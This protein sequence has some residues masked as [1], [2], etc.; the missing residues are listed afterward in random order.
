[1]VKQGQ[2]MRTFKRSLDWSWL[3]CVPLATEDCPPDV[4]AWQDPGI[5]PVGFDVDEFKGFFFLFSSIYIK[6]FSSSLLYTRACLLLRRNIIVIVALKKRGILR[7]GWFLC[8]WWNNFGDQLQTHTRTFFPAPMQN[9]F[10][11]RAISKTT[12][13][14]WISIIP[15]PFKSSTAWIFSVH[16]IRDKELTRHL[17]SQAWMKLASVYKSKGAHQNLFAF[18]AYE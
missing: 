13:M 16:P 15:F 9:Q 1:M 8:V 4:F 18:H 2:G 11:S 10:S 6:D 12:R 7:K 5:F 14:S 3:D 17:S